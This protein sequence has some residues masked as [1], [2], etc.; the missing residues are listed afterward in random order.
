MA[1]KKAD[2]A[3]EK[4]ADG[5]GQRKK[6]EELREE[7]IKLKARSDAIHNDV[8][9]IR[10]TLC[11]EAATLLKLQHAK[12]KTKDGSIRNAI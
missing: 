7:S 6:W 2:L 10:S 12:K 5:R 3:A 8:V 9:D 1:E 11:R 4:A